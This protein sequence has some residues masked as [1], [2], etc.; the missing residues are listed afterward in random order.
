LREYMLSILEKMSPK[1][2]RLIIYDQLKPSYAKYYTQFEA[3]K[4]LSDRNF[5]NVR[6]HHR[7]GY[8]WTVIGTKPI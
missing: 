1:K 2:R 3:R 7:H 5:E 4:L 8:S 6:V